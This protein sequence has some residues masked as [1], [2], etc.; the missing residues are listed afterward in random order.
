VIFYPPK[1][2]EIYVWL[3]WSAHEDADPYSYDGDTLEGIFTNKAQ[4]EAAKRALE[5][6]HADM[7]Y[8]IGEYK[9]EAH[10][11]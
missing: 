11:R 1:D 7:R 2:A 6:T 8:W 10:E 3:L 4:A 9:T 5:A